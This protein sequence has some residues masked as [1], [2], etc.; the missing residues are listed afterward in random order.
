MMQGLRRAT[1][2]ALA[3]VALAAPALAQEGDIWRVYPV[4]GGGGSLAALAASEVES[5]EPY[6]RFAMT[7]MPGEP[8]DA[9]VSGIEPAVLGAA[10]AAG[11]ELKVAVIA[12]GD[13]DKTPL[14]GYFP[15]ITFGQMFGEWEFSVPFDLITLDELG[16]AETL[17]VS[18]TGIDFA[19]PSAGTA[20]AFAEFRA[21]CAGLP[22][23]E[24]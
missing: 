15:E 19:L 22:P 11:G 4:E 3:G 9:V 17:A 5:P 12:D 14:S 7:C 20:D 6:W 21:L 2:A 23:P 8:G 16:A 24:G 18:G 13:P 1:P 10:I